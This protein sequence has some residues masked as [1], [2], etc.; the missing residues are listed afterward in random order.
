[1]EITNP[2]IDISVAAMLE[3]RA[4]SVDTLVWDTVVYGSEYQQQDITINS[5]P[6]CHNLYLLVTSV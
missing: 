1:M 6:N 2:L 3:P 5:T 4:S